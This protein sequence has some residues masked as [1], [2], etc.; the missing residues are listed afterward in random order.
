MRSNGIIERSQ[1]PQIGSI[2][3]TSKTSYVF[4]ELATVAIPSNRVNTSNYD[5]IKKYT[6]RRRSQSPQIGSILQT[7]EITYRLWVRLKSQSP[8]IGSILQTRWIIKE[9]SLAPLDSWQYFFICLF[10][11][12]ALVKIASALKRFL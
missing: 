7:L 1:S 12:S 5:Q 9:R 11:T 10:F 2:L 4:Y 3:Q 6:N 8:Q